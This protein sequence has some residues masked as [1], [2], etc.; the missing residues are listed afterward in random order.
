MR[1]LAAKFVDREAAIRVL[2]QLRAAYDLGPHD[3][4]IAPF[5]ET[6]DGRDGTITLLAGRFHDARLNAI[7]DAIDRAGGTVVADVDEGWT[8]PR[9][10]AIAVAQ[11]EAPRH[12]KRRAR[13]EAPTRTRVVQ[14]H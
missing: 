2:E 14:R 4:D 3:A 5:H 10:T 7:R 11:Q 8:H 6:E 12:D 9:S 13:P 1:V